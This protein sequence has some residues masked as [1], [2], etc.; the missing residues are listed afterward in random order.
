MS[1]PTYQRRGREMY[2]VKATGFQLR[3]VDPSGP[4]SRRCHLTDRSRTI[5][6]VL[7][8]T[9]MLVGV[10]LCGVLGQHMAWQRLHHDQQTATSGGTK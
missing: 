1:A 4:R 2:A 7:A 6:A 10:G 9:V 5:L 3:D 8:V